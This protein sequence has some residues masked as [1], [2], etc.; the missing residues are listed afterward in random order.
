[1]SGHA[2]IAIVGGGPIGAAFALAVREYGLGVTLLEARAT[3]MGDDSRTLALSYGSK[4]ILER[5]GVWSAELNETP[6]ES[7]HVSQRGG[8]GR[9]ILRAQD[10]GVPALGYTIGYARLARALEQALGASRVQVQR[11][12][13]VT[14]VASTGS[15]AAIHFTQDSA[16]QLLTAKLAV[17]ADGVVV[18]APRRRAPRNAREIT[19]KAPSSV[20]SNAIGPTVTLPSSA[21]QRM[22]RW[23]CCRAKKVTRWYGLSR[24]RK[25]KNC[26]PS[27]TT[28]SLQPFKRILASARECFRSRARAARLRSRCANPIRLRRDASCASVTPRKPCIRSQRKVLILACAT[29]GNWRR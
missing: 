29:Y 10:A 14:N 12:A 5:L 19:G 26:W 7:V 4:I 3:Q 24:Q 2:D 21:L 15:Y 27:T 11:G 25:L 20:W 28:H 23:R 13:N 8:F 18:A 9:T 6:I 22:A 16:T 17:L 1:V